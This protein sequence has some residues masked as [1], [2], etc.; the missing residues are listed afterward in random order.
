MEDGFEKKAKVYLP[1]VIIIA[2][3]YLFLPSILVFT[4]LDQK[5]TALTEIIYIGIFPL[6]ALLCNTVFCMKYK[7][8]FFMSLVAPIMYIPSAFLYG[9]FRANVLTTLIYL[10]SYF[11]CGYLGLIIGDLLKGRTK[12]EGEDKN[13]KSSKSRGNSY[14]RQNKTAS[15]VSRRAR[16]EQNIRTE[17]KISEKEEQYDFNESTSTEDDIDAILKEIHERQNRGQ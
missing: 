2:V 9:N 17:N 16:E 10:A 5:Q 8:E 6:T 13:K 14:R 7:N 15:H 3:V 1:Y 12:E 11:V 4:G